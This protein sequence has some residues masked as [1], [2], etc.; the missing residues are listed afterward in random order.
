MI[1]PSPWT[2]YCQLLFSTT[3][4]LS[5]EFVTDEN[6]TVYKTIDSSIHLTTPDF[7]SWPLAQVAYGWISSVSWVC[8]LTTVTPPISPL[9]GALPSLYIYLDFCGL[10]LCCIISSFADP[11]N[12]FILSPPI[13]IALNRTHN[14]PL[15]S[16]KHSWTS[17]EKIRE[18][19]CLIWFF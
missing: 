9:L 5:L 19:I 12:F 13:L 8:H 7:P 17:L 11:L 6:C 15:C 18:Q 1:H 10:I 2:S 3:L 14:A 4:Q 16:H